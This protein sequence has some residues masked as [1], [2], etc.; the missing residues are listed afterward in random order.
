M[1]LLGGGTVITPGWNAVLEAYMEEFGTQSP[2]DR[3]QL[4]CVI[5]TD[6]EAHDPDDFKAA[7]EGVKNKA[8]VIIVVVGFGDDHD[9]A[10]AQ[11]QGIAAIND[12]VRVV[13][14]DS[15]TNP[16]VISDGILSMLGAQ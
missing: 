16:S 9:K 6:G 1:G 10:L 13:T 14:F 8:Y 7:M 3:P 2:M 15:V 11:Y 5:V 4:A 12:H